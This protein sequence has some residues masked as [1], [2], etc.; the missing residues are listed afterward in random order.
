MIMNS[1]KVATLRMILLISFLFFNSIIVKA[2]NGSIEI[3]NL[4]YDCYVNNEKG[5]KI[6]SHIKVNGWKDKNV[7]YSVFFYK[8]SD[9]SNG[10]LLSTG[11]YTTP[12]GQVCAFSNSKSDYDNCE[13]K[14]WSLFI[15]YSALPHNSG[16]NHYSLYAVIRKTGDYNW[17]QIASTPY[18]NFHVEFNKPS[19]SNSVVNSTSKDSG[20]SGTFTKTRLE[21]DDSSKELKV[22]TSFNV[23]G[24]L[25]KKGT[26]NVYLYDYNKKGWKEVNK[27]NSCSTFDGHV[28]T[29]TNITPSYDNSVY[30]DLCVTL[31]F[32]ECDFTSIN[33]MYYI[34][35][36]LFI[37]N[38]QIC[39][40]DYMH[41]DAYKTNGYSQKKCF[42]CFDGKCAGC[43]GTG[44][45][46]ACS[47]YG[48]WRAAGDFYPCTGCMGTG[49]CRLCGGSGVC[50]NCGGHYITETPDSYKVA[51]QSSEYCKRND[52]TN[53]STAPGNPPVVVMP[54]TSNPYI[55][56]KIWTPC[57][58]C[59]G[60]GKCP[61]CSGTGVAYIHTYTDCITCH[62]NGIC[63]H[64]HGA[65]GYYR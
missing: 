8:G 59:S 50:R 25:G 17:E 14:D 18:K 15:P 53:S 54:V 31:P 63:I 40:S 9:G 16:N 23:Q 26:V 49:T 64:C 4:E 37:D 33:Q 32:S 51:Y 65:G 41:F 29:H 60:N 55:N 27:N 11:K 61:T 12:N 30:T 44:R 45:C 34:N 19:S 28:A 3:I 38:K 35:A 7:N 57:V 1:S 5:M 24:A 10:K 62:G 20:V 22:Y 21:I 2:Q 42:A 48:G 46:S 39:E 58:V 43:M 47:G 13:W 56:E 52:K 6:H 36:C